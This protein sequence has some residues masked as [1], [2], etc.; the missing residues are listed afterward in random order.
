[1]DQQTPSVQ[2]QNKINNGYKSISYGS[3]TIMYPP[4]NFSFNKAYFNTINER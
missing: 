4:E 2:S 3:L 1:M